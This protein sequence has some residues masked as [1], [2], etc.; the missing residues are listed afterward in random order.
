MDGQPLL[1]PVSTPG[2]ALALLP[3]VLERRDNTDRPVMEKDEGKI[4]PTRVANGRSL[5]IT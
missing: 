1:E 4:L 5:G 3:G 2:E